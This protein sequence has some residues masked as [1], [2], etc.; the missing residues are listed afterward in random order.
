LS[1]FTSNLITNGY[2]ASDGKWRNDVPDRSEY[3]TAPIRVLFLMMAMHPEEPVRKR[4]ELNYK[5]KA[6]TD[7]YYNTS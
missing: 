5:Y 1:V 3:G 2:L 7:G 4:S 6:Q